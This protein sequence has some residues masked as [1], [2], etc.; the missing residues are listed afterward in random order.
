MYHIKF[1]MTKKC[2]LN[3]LKMLNSDNDEKNIS[4]TIFLF[5]YDLSDFSTFERMMLYCGSLNR[6][7]KLN[8]NKVKCFIMGNKSEKK[9]LLNKEDNEKMDSFFKLDSNFKKFEISNKLHFNFSKFLNELIENCVENDMNYDK[10]KLKSI[11]ENKFPIFKNNNHYNNN[12]F[13]FINIKLI[14]KNYEYY[15]LRK[16]QILNF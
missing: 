9:M 5:M 2:I 7:F 12:K 16:L 14:Y 1:T 15:Y 11:L 13:N 10:E 6:K 8:E 3:Y 4:E